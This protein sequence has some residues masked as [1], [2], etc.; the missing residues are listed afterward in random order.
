MVSGWD[1]HPPEYEPDIGPWG[2][3]LITLFVLVVVAAVIGVG[4]A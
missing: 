2:R 1:K 4:F 3:A